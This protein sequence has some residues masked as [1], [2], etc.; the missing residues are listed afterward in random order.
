MTLSK[1]N[2]KQ[3][4]TMKTNKMTT[5]KTIA[6]AA[7]MAL[8]LSS[9]SERME[10]PATPGAPALLPVVRAQLA[11]FEGGG[12]ALEG[13]NTLT[14]LRACLFVDGTLAKVYTLPVTPDAGRGV[15]LERHAGTLYVVAN[16]EGLLDLDALQQQGSLSESDWKKM[17]VTTAGKAPANFFSGSISLDGLENTQTELPVTL[18]RGVA[19]FD[20]QIR[21][22]GRASVSS[23]TLKNAAQSAYLFPV[24]GDLSPEAV[25]RQ[26][27][28]ATISEPL[29]QDTPAVLYAYE[30]ENDNLTVEIVAEIDGQ[31]KT[32]TKQLG[33]ALERN[34]IYTL[35][36]RKD[37]IDV[38][39]DLSFDEW[40]PGG[41]TEL[42]PAR[43]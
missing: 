28:A 37:V 8:G 9:C 15:Q 40:E 14:D 33:T 41:D 12:Q 18:R 31:V 20:L 2:V 35:T 36:V 39:L 5:V 25:S 11:A 19:R 17:A 32:L 23:I 38:S 27:V 29:T 21:T 30:Q 34:K 3:D 42:T 43:R 10:T 6:F 16:T 26:D 24:E 13:E 4:K 1:Q 22:A 7:A